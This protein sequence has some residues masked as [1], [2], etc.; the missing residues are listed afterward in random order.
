[1]EKVIFLLIFSGLH[2]FKGL[3]TGETKLV[4]DILTAAQN[5]FSRKI[6]RELFRAKS[7]TIRFFI[8]PI[9]IWVDFN[10]YLKLRANTNFKHE[11]TVA[12]NGNF[13]SELS[14]GFEYDSK[15][16]NGQK[17]KTIKSYKQ[18]DIKDLLPR[19]VFKT[20]IDITNDISLIPEI[21]ILFFSAAGLRLGFVPTLDVNL[22]GKFGNKNT[23]QNNQVFYEALFGLKGYTQ[24]LKIK[25][26][27]FESSLGGLL[28][29]P[30]D[31][32]DEFEIIG[33]KTLK[34]GCFK[35]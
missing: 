31:P 19:P 13:T 10:S 29:Y 16:P 15:R 33:K 30:K 14:L 4:Y 20:E 7:F 2:Y 26:W 3:V 17:F 34:N 18:S 35:F 21:Q 11:T 9:P 5:G 28:P 1:L 8:G 12:F 23:C 25:L 22:K 27:K 32:I 24:L 6:E